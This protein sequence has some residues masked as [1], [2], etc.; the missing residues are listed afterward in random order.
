MIILDEPTSGLD[1]LMQQTFFELIA[2]ENKRGATVL[3]SSHVLSEV[4]RLCGRVAIIKEGR[5]VTVE[6]IATL[7][8]TSYK[9]F[10]VE[11][12]AG[13]PAGYFAATGVKTCRKKAARTVFCTK[14]ISTR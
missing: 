11:A 10:K 12:A 5:I 13:I 7:Q 3:M 2:E 8:Q 4:Q 14:A 6:K 1:P 9:R